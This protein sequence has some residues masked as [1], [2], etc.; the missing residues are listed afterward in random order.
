MGR[1]GG[2]RSA[3]RVRHA[4]VAALALPPSPAAASLQYPL[5]DASILRVKGKPAVEVPLD[6]SVYDL[7][8][9]K[10]LSWCPKN[11]VVSGWRRSRRS[12]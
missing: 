8:T 4:D 7:A 2:G 6:G 1:Q 9:G 11:T 10:V 3:Q 12:A 5:A